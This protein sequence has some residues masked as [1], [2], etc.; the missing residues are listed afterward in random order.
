MLGAGLEADRGA[1]WDRVFVQPRPGRLAL[2][3]V[4]TNEVRGFIISNPDTD[5]PGLDFIGALH[6]A[7]AARGD[8]LGALLMREWADRMTGIGRNRAKLIVADDNERGRAFYRRIGGVESDVFADDLGVDAHAPARRVTWD[9]I[10]VIAALAR[11]ETIRRLAPPA[12]LAAADVQ[13]WTRAIHPVAAADAAKARRKQPL[14]DP[15]GLSDFG[16]N[17]VEIDPG[18][19]ST[20]RHFHS[21]EDEFVMVLEGELTLCLG[22]RE[23]PMRPG[24]CAGFP[25]GEGPSHVLENRSEEEVGVYLEIGSRWPDRDICRYPGQDLIVDA[26]PDGNRWFLRL[27]G[28]PVGPAD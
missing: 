24:D 23:F 17:R 8:G 10:A 21:H 26:G 11:G 27:D 20:V 18:T 13:N 19:V 5:D 6:V 22:E 1:L 15:F 3:A 7:P 4:K 12:M 2:V 16:V 25:A 9:D 28:T 14:G